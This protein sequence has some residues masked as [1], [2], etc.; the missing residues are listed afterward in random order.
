MVTKNNVIFLFIVFDLILGVIFYDFECSFGF[1]YIDELIILLLGCFYVFLNIADG[2]YRIKKLFLLFI[3]IISGYL[4]YSFII[5]SNTNQAIIS[6]FL[7]FIK[8]FLAFFILIEL[9]PQLSPSHMKILKNIAVIASFFCLIIGSIFG[10]DFIFF[11]FGHPS[12]FATATIACGMLFFYA[13]KFSLRTIIIT[14]LIFS[15]GLFSLRSKM[16]GFLI[17][18]F[19]SLLYTYRQFHYKKFKISIKAIIPAIIMILACLFVAREKIFFYFIRGSNAEKMYARPLLY[20]TGYKILQDYFPL[21]SG[22]GSFA[23]FYSGISYSKIYSKYGIDKAHGLSKDNT[24][25]IC[26]TFYPQLIG[27]F[28]FL[29]IILFFLF[30]I[31]IIINAYKRILYINRSCQLFILMLLIF[32]FFM[33]ESVAD[34]TFVHNRGIFVMMIFALATNEIQIIYKNQIKNNTT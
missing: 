18:A 27:Q 10:M 11:W 31:T 23:S 2:K 9:K 28:G 12:R 13:S 7:V 1:T 25:F 14:I 20:V 33:I 15:I 32:A 8:G 21:G 26:D 22:F 30:W 24:G 29:G 16:Y 5:K 6:D 34:S 19:F 3:F 17:L 4:L